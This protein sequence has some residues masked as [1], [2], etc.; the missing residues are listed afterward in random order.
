M[1]RLCFQPEEQHPFITIQ[2]LLVSAENFAPAEDDNTLHLEEL[3]RQ[4][5]G[6]NDEPSRK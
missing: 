4:E 5:D 1:D 3:V 2:Q 6:S